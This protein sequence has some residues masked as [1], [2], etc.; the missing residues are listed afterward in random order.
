LINRELTSPQPSDAV[1][2]LG[3]ASRYLDQ[4]PFPIVDATSPKL[5]FFYFQYRPTRLRGP[6]LPDS[7]THAIERVK[8]RLIHI[9]SP[10]DFANAIV[11]L[12]RAAATSR[13][14]PPN[15]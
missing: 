12:E 11:Q 15:Q 1:V 9:T 14:S 7:I 3:P 5:R 10:A 8:G 2:F 13:T 4:I 6:M